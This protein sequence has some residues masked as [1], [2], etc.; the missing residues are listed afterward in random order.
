MGETWLI[1]GA[2]S[3]IARAF[4]RLV[5]R[6]GDALL[7]AGRDTEELERLAADLRVRG[8]ARTTVLAFDAGQPAGH[9]RV[10][11]EAAA[12]AADGPLNVLLAFG[13]LADQPQVEAAPDLALRLIE[14]NFTGAAS[15]LLRLAP[16]LESRR[17]GR[18]VAVGSV[19]GD[20]GRPSNFVY[21][22][23]KAGL[24]AFLEGYRARLFRAG[25]SVTTI[26]PGFTDTAMTWG[27]PGMFLVASPEAV[28]AACLAHARN[29][30][31]TAYVPAFWG[32]IMAVVRLMPEALFK[33]LRL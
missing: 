33:R 3:A 16:V 32:A 9:D 10:V 5:A 15:I 6:E 1:L 21:G 19:A 26:K 23:A 12:A 11:A 17:C 13:A 14:T 28:A 8:A 2:T 25:V 24:H 31:D 30:A 22:A 4:A 20:R 27:K 7:L 18:V 29:K